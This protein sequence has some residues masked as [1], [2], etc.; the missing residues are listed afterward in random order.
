MSILL[1]LNLENATRRSSALATETPEGRDSIISLIFGEKRRRAKRTQTEPNTPKSYAG[2]TTEDFDGSKKD[3]EKHE[4][5]K[6]LDIFEKP[7]KDHADGRAIHRKLVKNTFF[8]ENKELFDEKLDSEGIICLCK[9]LALETFNENEIIYEKGEKLNDKIYFVYKGEVEVL[10]LGEVATFKQSNFS[11]MSKEVIEGSQQPKPRMSLIFRQL[12]LES[13]ITHDPSTG[14]K[15]FNLRGFMATNPHL[16]T[17]AGRK[18][19]SGEYFGGEILNGEQLEREETLMAK[20][21]THLLV[22]NLKDFEYVKNRYDKETIH[23]L[24]YITQYLSVI[25]QHQPEVKNTLFHYMAE[26]TLPLGEILIN[27]GDLE[28]HFYFLYEGKCEVQKKMKEMPADGGSPKLATQ[29]TAPICLVETGTFLGEELLFKPL[30]GYDYTIKVTSAKAIFF[31]F[32]VKKFRHNFDKEILDGIKE[33]YEGKSKKHQEIFENVSKQI[34]KRNSKIFTHPILNSKSPTPNPHPNLGLG[35]RWDAVTAGSYGEQDTISTVTQRNDLISTKRILARLE[36]PISEKSP[37]IEK[38]D[39]LTNKGIA[40]IRDQIKS[41]HHQ[42]VMSKPDRI[43]TEEG[44]HSPVNPRGRNIRGTGK[45]YNTEHDEWGSRHR[46]DSLDEMSRVNGRE[47]IALHSNKMEE[48][49][50]SIDN[51]D[52]SPKGSVKKPRESRL[53]SDIEHF[54]LVDSPFHHKEHKEISTERDIFISQ[55]GKIK[56]NDYAQSRS[57][58]RKISRS[59][60]VP[61]P[62]INLDALRSQFFDSPKI[63]MRDYLAM[64]KKANLQNKLSRNID[65]IIQPRDGEFVKLQKTARVL[66]Q[67]NN[68]HSPKMYTLTE[69]D[70]KKLIG[71]KS[72]KG[73]IPVGKM[74]PGRRSEQVVLEP[75]FE[76]YRQAKAMSKVRMTDRELREK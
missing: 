30:L 24:N 46:L 1:K 35:N 22:M 58:L 37:K 54:R 60:K 3:T 5:D 39:S 33:R 4:K 73:L 48:Y 65:A 49:L 56:S 74:T 13:E 57:P 19:G 12:N 40:V 53:L 38:R 47:K 76:K 62:K 28:D 23:K 2:S 66:P 75:I 70:N 18:I 25:I 44:N 43:I 41:F 51:M 34:N 69:S 50:N 63:S 68:D 32:E 7:E 11:T 45:N 9:R 15:T 36:G 67:L 71:S 27:E 59:V 6:F 61:S 8:E 14:K 31:K 20:T 72:A 42:M 17:L 29:K 21:E 10:Q 52:M 64:Y 26:K 16:K 55:K